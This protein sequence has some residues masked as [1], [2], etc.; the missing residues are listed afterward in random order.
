M[1][2]DDTNKLVSFSKPML[3]SHN[4]NISMKNKPVRS[5]L[6]LMGDMPSDVKIVE[7][8]DYTECLKIGFINDVQT[9]DLED[10]KKYFDVLVMH[11]G[12][13]TVLE[14]IMAAVLREDFNAELFPSL[15]E[16]G[17]CLESVL[18]ANGSIH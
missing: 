15:E 4:K 1:E 13:L 10:F 16:V 8:C 14:M 17:E 9:Y 3:L 2:W 18:S 6:I 11:D 12:N 7:P 5:H